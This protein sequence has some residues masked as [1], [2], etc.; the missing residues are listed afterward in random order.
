MNAPILGPADWAEAAMPKAWD[1]PLTCGY[2]FAWL[3]MYV[4]GTKSTEDI[5][6]WHFELRTMW[7][8][9][10]D[11]VGIELDEEVRMANAIRVDRATR[12]TLVRAAGETDAPPQ[13]PPL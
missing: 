9:Y 12:S 11:Q 3:D 10:V 5:Y 7:N 6:E 2:M 4:N 8:V 13:V 1:F